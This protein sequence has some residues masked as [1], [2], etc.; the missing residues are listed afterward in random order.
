[1]T[2]AGEAVRL[3]VDT[4]SRDLVSFKAWTPTDLQPTAWRGAKTVRYASGPARL[5]RLELR[6]VGMGG[7]TFDRLTAWSLDREPR[8]YPAGIDGV[9]GV[10]ALGCQRVRFDFERSEF[11][12]SR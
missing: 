10:L 7:H 1:M 11:G 2:I 5:V 8:G 9:V 3:L 12:W 4:G 6:Q